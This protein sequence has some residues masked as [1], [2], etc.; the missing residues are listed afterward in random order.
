MAFGDGGGRGIPL[1]FAL[2]VLASPGLLGVAAPASAAIIAPGYVVSEIATSDTAVGAVEVV[3]GTVFVG[4]GPFFT[5]AG[6]A[7][8]RIDGSGETVIADGFNS[9]AGMAYDPVNDRLI[10]GDNGFEA[11]GSETGD[12]LYGIA[13][14]LGP[15]A[16]PQRAMDIELLDPESIDFVADLVLDP[17]DPTNQSLF[18]TN[19]SLPGELLGVDLDALSVSVLQSSGLAYGAGVAADADSVFFGDSLSAGTGR[20]SEVSL[21]APS[22]A[23]SDLI[24]GMDGQSGLTLASD[25]T[26][27]ATSSVFGA[28]SSLLRIDPGDGSILETVG[29]GFDFAGP[30]AE[31]EGVIYVL[32]G[33]FTAGSRVVVLTPVPEP[34]VALLLAAGLALL[35][36]G[37]SA[38]PRGRVAGHV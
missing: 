3:G 31:E 23:R 25:G 27:L 12:T 17:R 11:S 18:V 35:P 5:G 7:V 21:L 28:S 32:E 22:G 16:T 4:V 20:I 37:R 19:G 30:L 38:R 29:S 26:L 34:G 8:V 24:D 9:L 6:Q 1:A 36:L 15:V 2:A 33:G 14:P 10:V 13:D